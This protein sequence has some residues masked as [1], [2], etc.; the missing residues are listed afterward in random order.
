MPSKRNADLKALGKSAVS[1]C[2]LGNGYALQGKR[3]P[4]EICSIFTVSTTGMNRAEGD[5]VHRRPVLKRSYGRMCTPTCIR[6]M[7]RLTSVGATGFDDS[8]KLTE[9][10]RD[11]MF[12]EIKSSEYLGWNV[13]TLR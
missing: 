1:L 9:E 12:E 2:A 6:L 8:K 11:R 3:P 10:T 7:V 5:A 4:A 13:I